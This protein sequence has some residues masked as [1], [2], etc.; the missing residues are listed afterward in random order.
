MSPSLPPATDS[1]ALHTDKV[2]SGPIVIFHRRTVLEVDWI[3]PAAYLD[4][5]CIAE[6]GGETLRIDGCRGNHQ[7]ELGTF[8]QDSLQITEQKIDIETALMSLIDNQRVVVLEPPIAG[9]L[10]KQN[11]VGH[12][13]DVSPWTQGVLEPDFVAHP[14]LVTELAREPTGHATRRDPAGL[15]MSNETRDPAAHL[16]ANLRYLGRF[17]RPGFTTDYRHLVVVD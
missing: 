8:P 10:S 3:A 17:T 12:D 2:V 1:I 5:R 4:D 16:E 9:E 15:G 6:V 14:L 7:L 13:F 11:T